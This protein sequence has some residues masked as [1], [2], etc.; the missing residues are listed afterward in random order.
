MIA[1][2]KLLSLSNTAFD[3]LRKR[4]YWRYR[5]PSD[6]WDDLRAKAAVR[7]F[8]KRGLYS[9]RRGAIE[10]WLHTVVDNSIKNGLRQSLGSWASA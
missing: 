5:L 1:H 10:S 3:N 6:E 7:V 8:A 9:K 2:A 4:K